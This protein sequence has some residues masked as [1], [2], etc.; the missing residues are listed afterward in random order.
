MTRSEKTLGWEQLG[1]LNAMAEERKVHLATLA[2]NAYAPIAGY[3]GNTVVLRDANGALVQLIRYR[4]DHTMS[5]WRDGVWHEGQW[6][7]NNGQDSSIVAH[8]RQIGGKAFTWCHVFAPHKRIGDRWISPET[9][10]GHPTYPLAGGGIPVVTLAGRTVVEGTDHAPGSVFSLEEGD[11]PP[12]QV[13]AEHSPL[14][15]ENDE[16]LID[17]GES[18]DEAMAGYFGNS[19]VMRDPSGTIIHILNYRPNHTVNGWRH[20]VWVE[21]HWLLNNAQDNST[22]L[23][24]RDL[25]ADTASWAH[26]FS[27]YKKLGDRWI[28]PETRGGHPPFPIEVGGIPVQT[29]DG[30]QVVAG[31]TY[32][33]SEI[34]S[35]EEGLVPAPWVQA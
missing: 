9:H 11:V 6:L 22:L 34:M 20:G 17:L 31:T 18:P 4:A 8:T 25:F 23:Q 30:K 28:A 16:Q 33:P 35:M 12:P 19:M 5:S 14:H 7:I 2:R 29:L 10:S 32:A 3:F 26:S 21:G 13:L 15:L 1:L 27:P 24:T